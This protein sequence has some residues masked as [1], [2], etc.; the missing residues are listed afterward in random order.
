M[1]RANAPFNHLLTHLLDVM[2]SLITDSFQALPLSSA[3]QLSKLT[4]QVLLLLA[5][6]LVETT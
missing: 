2:K 6:V 1:T 4:N 5:L 3:L